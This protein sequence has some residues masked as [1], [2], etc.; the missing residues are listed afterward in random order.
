VGLHRTWAETKSFSAHPSDWLISN[1]HNRLY[2]FLRNPNVNPE[3]WLFPGLLAIGVGC[4][5]LFNRNRKF[6]AIALTWIALGFI[7]SLGVHTFFHRFLFAHVPGFAAI[8]V[9]ARWASIA[10]VGLAMLVGSGATVIAK[11]RWVAAVLAVAFLIE[12]RSAP[13]R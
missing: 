2:T 11:R 12:L 9:P 1:F 13:I 6:T 4:V 5:G 8:R 7:G 10:Y 3:R